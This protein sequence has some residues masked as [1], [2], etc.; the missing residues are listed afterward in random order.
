[1]G[2]IWSLIAPTR[3]SYGCRCPPIREFR[4]LIDVQ[5]AIRDHAPG[6]DLRLRVQRG[7]EEPA[8]VRVS[9]GGAAP[10]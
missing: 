5:A 9:Q 7:G 4:D 10:V 6:E 3:V 1:M 8:E 2:L